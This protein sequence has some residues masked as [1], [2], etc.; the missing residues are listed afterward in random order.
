MKKDDAIITITPNPAIDVH[1][2]KTDEG[3][4]NVR[5][6]SGGKGV[7]VSRALLSNGAKSLCALFLGEDNAEDFLIPLRLEG[8]RLEYVTVKGAVRE[9]V[10]IQMGNEEL[11]IK[12]KGAMVDGGAVERLCQRLMPEIDEG[13]YLCFSG[14]ISEGSDK[15]AIIK[16]LKE[17]KERGARLLLD[18]ASLSGADISELKPY[19][20]KP[21]YEEAM[22]LVCDGASLSSRELVR[23]LLNLGSE[24]VLLTLG[25]RGAVLGTPDGVYEIGGVPITPLSTTGAGDAALAGFTLGKTR[26]VPDFE[27]LRLAVAFATASC[28]SEGS[29]PPDPCRIKEVIESIK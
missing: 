22:A 8:L 10:N 5:R 6:D 19:L 26:G 28:L 14:S 23:R 12:G 2:R 17:A 27:A 18:S 16:M 15:A 20:I 21:N 1:K 24:R 7:N 3:E 9:N 4:I 13:T 11:V 25:G 29:L